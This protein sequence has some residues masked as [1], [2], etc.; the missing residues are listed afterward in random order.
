MLSL[1]LA[2]LPGCS[3]R[4]RYIKAVKEKLLLPNG[5]HVLAPP[6]AG[7]YPGLVEAAD[8]DAI[9][10]IQ[11]VAPAQDLHPP[12]TIAS[13]S[14]LEH[15]ASFDA[16]ELLR[17]LTKESVT[18]SLKENGAQISD[19]E[20]VLRSVSRVTEQDFIAFG[21]RHPISTRTRDLLR[22]PKTSLAYEVGYGDVAYTVRTR[23]GSELNADAFGSDLEIELLTQGVYRLTAREVA[24]YWLAF[25]SNPDLP[26]PPPEKTIKGA[27]WLYVESVAAHVEARATFSG[28]TST[29]SRQL[30]VP[31]NVNSWT[32]RE[33]VEWRN[34]CPVYET[35]RLRLSPGV[36][37]CRFR[38]YSTGR[39]RVFLYGESTDPTSP[40]IFEA[41]DPLN[42]SEQEMVIKV[43][44]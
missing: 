41:R 16:D 43:E 17:V 23:Q 22:R 26:I 4:S 21:E 28:L 29:A 33:N 37:V 39:A 1:G 27:I 10:Q 30:T 34:D 25:A 38:A 6:T 24:L 14:S 19:V 9:D 5:A 42:T 11:I 20:V 35:T 18:A 31:E 40:L 8:K 32:L 3:A 2:F 7:I 12:V 13:S 36:W 15:S 44:E